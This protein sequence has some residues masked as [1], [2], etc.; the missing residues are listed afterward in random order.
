MLLCCC[1]VLSV[2]IQVTILTPTHV[3]QQLTSIC[4]IKYLVM[5]VYSVYL[6]AKESIMSKAWLQVIKID[7]VSNLDLLQQSNNTNLSHYPLF[8][9]LSTVATEVSIGRIHHT[10]RV[11]VLICQDIIIMVEMEQLLLDLELCHH[12]LHQ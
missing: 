9:G 5:Y 8:R 10:M 12:L 3:E 11:G 7:N 6:Q 1:V 2:I 4:K